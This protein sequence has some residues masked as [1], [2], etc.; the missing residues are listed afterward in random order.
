LPIQPRQHDQHQGAVVALRAFGQLR[1]RGAAVLAGLARWNSD[2]HDLPIG[3]EAQR[4]TRRQHLAP[5]EVRSR[6]RVHSALGVALGARC[7]ADRVRRF[8]HKQR[9]VAVQRVERTQTLAEVLRQ[10]G[11][12]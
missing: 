3:K 6:D 11:G 2:L 4:A 7:R 8:L 12:R 10:L 1:Q 5:V 9:L